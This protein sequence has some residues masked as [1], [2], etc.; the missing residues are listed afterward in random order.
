MSRGGTNA[1]E[2]IRQA[3]YRCNNIKGNMMPDEWTAFMAANPYWWA[4]QISVKQQTNLPLAKL[5]PVSHLR[6]MTAEENARRM[7]AYRAL[8][9]TG[10][11][12]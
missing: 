2:N 6:S 3:C 5:A 9:M 12:S 7:G 8:Q 10:R 4:A 11:T 1:K